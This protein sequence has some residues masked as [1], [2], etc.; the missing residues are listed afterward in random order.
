MGK[1]FSTLGRA[2]AAPAR[3]AMLNVLMDGSARPAAELAH[4]GGVS[5]AAASE[6]LAGCWAPT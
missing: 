5:R 4:V 6:H 3:S 1:D 2:L